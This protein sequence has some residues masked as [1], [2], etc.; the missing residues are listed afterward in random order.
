[1]PWRIAALP[2]DE[3]GYPV[4]FFVAMVDGKPDHRVMDG[5][6]MPRALNEGLC[7]ICGGKLGV[8]KAFCIGPMCAVTRTISE[9][10]SHLECA[11]WAAQAC[12]FLTRPRAKRREAN[13]PADAV[14]Q[15]TEGIRRNPG[16]VC[17]WVTK[18]FRPFRAPSGALL[19]NLGEP[20]STKWIAEGRDATREEVEESIRTGLP[21]LGVEKEGPA[22]A[23]ELQRRLAVVERLL[24]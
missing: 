9:P 4:P 2:V 8:Y 13:M 7:W 20:T 14:W 6:K 5:E 22:A 17:V 18:S 1:M 12:P 16:A 3:R 24:P 21:L 11:T 19:F 23:R 10:P 15:G